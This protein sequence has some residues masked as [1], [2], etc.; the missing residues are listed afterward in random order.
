MSRDQDNQ[1]PLDDFWNEAPDQQ[2]QQRSLFSRSNI[3][4]DPS[5]VND[6]Q[7]VLIDELEVKTDQK[8]ILEEAQAVSKKL[9][10]ALTPELWALLNALYDQS[11][12][13]GLAVSRAQ[14]IRI[15]IQHFQMSW[16]S[17]NVAPKPRARSSKPKENIPLKISTQDEDEWSI[18]ANQIDAGKKKTKI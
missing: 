3:F 1:K 4:N 16:L 2:D 13:L 11:Q 7:S 18:D 12:V 9:N 17:E 8:S 10:V 6:A 14:M 5:L 15:A